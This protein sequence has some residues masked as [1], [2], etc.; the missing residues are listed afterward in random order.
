MRI[1]PTHRCLYFHT[2]IFVETYLI[3]FILLHVYIK[4]KL[5]IEKTRSRFMI[6]IDLCSI[7]RFSRCLPLS[8]ATYVHLSYILL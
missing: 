4:K 1:G 6:V 3:F 8:L 7:S 5:S 2:Y